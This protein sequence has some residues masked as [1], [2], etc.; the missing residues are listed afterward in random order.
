MRSSPSAC[1]P[2]SIF[3]LLS[4]GLEHHHVISCA[5]LRQIAVWSKELTKPDLAHACEGI[6]ERTYSSG[7]FIC[8]QGDRLD[9]WA[10]VVSG[11]IKLSTFSKG[12]KQ[13]TLAGIRTGGWFGE[14]ALLKDEPRRYDLVAL[15][16][17]ELALMDR[18]T[19]QWLFK[20][21]VGFT[22]F[23]VHQFNERLGQFIALVE[24]ER[25]LDA[26]AR[27][28]RT[29][30]WLFN[31]TLYPEAGTHLDISQEELGL[32]SGISRYWTNKNLKILERENLLRVERD[33][34]TIVDLGR[35]AS[36]E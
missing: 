32:L 17:T 19:F 33:G 21:S 36:Y 27:L 7:A 25:A 3:R 12:G 6:I 24:N 15:R 35:L 26:K 14:G 2:F 5:R 31:A 4:S 34:L 8:H 30:A 9:S 28:A 20:N 10:G 1:R 13:V 11:L 22:R 18:A 16:D 29:I 23:L